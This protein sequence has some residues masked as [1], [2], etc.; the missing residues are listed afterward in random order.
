MFIYFTLFIGNSYL[1]HILVMSINFVPL[2]RGK[3]PLLLRHLGH[4]GST[5]AV[6]I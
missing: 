5:V 4:L 3:A 6:I 2:H 1:T